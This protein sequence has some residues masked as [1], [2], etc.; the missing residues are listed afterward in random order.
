MQ[1]YFKQNEKLYDLDQMNCLAHYM[2]FWH[3]ISVAE[4]LGL[5]W[6]KMESLHGVD[7]EHV[8]HVLCEKLKID[9]IHLHN[10]SNAVNFSYVALEANKRITYATTGCA[11]ALDSAM[12]FCETKLDGC[13]RINML[14]AGKDIHN[15]KTGRCT[16]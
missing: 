1:E 15:S 6:I 11:Q 8:V 5:P 13:A 7:S 12:H 3:L 14:Y 9:S 2:H 10:V 4:M 16:R